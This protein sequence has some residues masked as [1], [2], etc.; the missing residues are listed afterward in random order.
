MQISRWND[1]A[2]HLASLQAWKTQ[3]E[4]AAI[5]ECMRI[6]GEYAKEDSAPKPPTTDQ[7]VVCREA[8]EAFIDKYSTMKSLGERTVESFKGCDQF[9]LFQ[10]GWNA[11]QLERESGADSKLLSQIAKII[12]TDPGWD[13]TVVRIE[14][15]LMEAG[16]DDQGRRGRD[17]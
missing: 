8:F 5:Q 3:A 2:E 9:Q 12:K 7:P 10:A 11:R 13:T 14:E 15:L 17:D 4:C 16:F 6:V 1:L